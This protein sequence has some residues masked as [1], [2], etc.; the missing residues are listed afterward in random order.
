MEARQKESLRSTIE[1]LDF[2]S[3]TAEKDTLLETARI[4]TSVFSDIVDDRVDL[5]LGTKGSGKTA[6]FNIF[7]KYLCD[8]FCNDYRIIIL[9]G[10]E[11]P[12]GD[13]IF[14]H[15]KSRFNELTDI[16]FQNFWRVYFVAL[17]NNSAFSDS[18]FEKLFSPAK[19]EIAE[20]QSFCIKNNFP[21]ERKAKTLRGTVNW[22]LNAVKKLKLR[23]DYNVKGETVGV[24]IDAQPDDIEKSVEETSG[25]PIFINEIR[26]KILGILAKTRF[27][28]WIFVDRLDEIFERRSEIERKALRSLLLTTNS[29]P[30]AS[31]RLKLFLRN[32]IFSSLI[33]HAT[34]FTALTHVTD[35][36]SDPLA[37]DP[38][39]IC[40]LIVKRIYSSQTLQEH[41]GIDKKRLDKDKEYQSQ[42]FY[43][44]FPQKVVQGMETLD[45]IYSRCQDGKGVV[46]PR[47][48]IDLLKAARNRQLDLVMQC[49]DE[50]TDVIGFPA[51]RYGY[52]KMSERKVET[53]LQAEFPH[54][55]GP[56]LSKFR[57]QKSTHTK[58]SLERLLETNEPKII[59]E[60]EEL[61]F[62]KFM[63][64]KT[65][66]TIPHIYRYGMNLS[67][68]VD[69]S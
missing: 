54:L 29:F 63:P 28:I 6:L 18:R 12:S 9:N 32:D 19:Q 37:W 58:S 56:Y 10:A 4:E 68:G 43:K 50:V 21:F 24:S 5:I 67:Q 47:D 39:L 7:T 48:V 52:E 49:P 65:L 25:G 69:R 15:F 57:H 51:L 8:T 26:R 38:Q 40:K 41:F 11:E 17:I 62:L 45:W 22:A 13:Q 60:L 16:E 53:F 34:G 46:T 35:R 23:V 30:D 42:C 66:Y 61:G 27:K 1:S 59:R 64:K 20:F 36:S 33:D 55:W 3:S 14:L 2:G 44:V 31:L